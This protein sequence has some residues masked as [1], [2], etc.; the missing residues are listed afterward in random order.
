MW[1][2]ELD[3]SL[4]GAPSRPTP[5]LWSETPNEAHRT[6][7]IQQQAFPNDSRAGHVAGKSAGYHPGYP[8]SSLAI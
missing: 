7:L 5:R 8:G 4:T 6:F 2:T 1:P 3:K